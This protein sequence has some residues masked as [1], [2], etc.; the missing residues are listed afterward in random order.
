MTEA[1][2]QGGLSKIS[3][4][5]YRLADFPEAVALVSFL[6]IFLFF[7]LA[8]PYFLT[9]IS[10]ANIL[11][12]ASINGIVAVGVAM[13]MISGEFDLSV[14]S[15]FA[16]ASYVFALSLTYGINPL[17]AVLLALFISALLG[18]ING[19][20]VIRSGIPSF[21]VTLGTLLAYRGI[22]RAIGGG[23]FADYRGEPL[24]LLTLLNGPIEFLNQLSRPASN[25]RLSILWFILIAAIMIL[26]LNRTQYGN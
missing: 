16:V 21:I 20:I 19:L 9:S 3:R 1:T 6:V 25:F 5:R 18:W 2:L 22:A 7:S 17:V 4:M 13:L 11:T 26:I 23:D 8:A 12:F 15:T 14:G 10:I 24:A